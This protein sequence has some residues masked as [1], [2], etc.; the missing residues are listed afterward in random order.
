MLLKNHFHFISYFFHSKIPPQWS[1][2]TTSS[3]TFKMSEILP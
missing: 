2:V 3:P 1:A